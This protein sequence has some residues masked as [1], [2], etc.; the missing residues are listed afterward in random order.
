MTTGDKGRVG[1]GWGTMIMGGA[2]FEE[3]VIRGGILTDVRNLKFVL[4][5]GGVGVVGEIRS[6]SRGRG[7]P[8]DFQ[9][10]Q[11]GPWPS[12]IR[13]V[14]TVVGWAKVGDEKLS[15]G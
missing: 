7:L 9:G 8:E 4:E 1:G 12:F 10:G 6:W 2:Q 14:D 11:G 15:P 5:G 13:M 3:G